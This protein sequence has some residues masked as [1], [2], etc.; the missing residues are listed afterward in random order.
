[1]ENKITAVIIDDETKSRFVLHTLITQNFP[2]IQLIGEASNVDEAYKLLVEV[3]PQLIFLDIQMPKSDGFTLLKHFEK[4][5]FEVVFV[6]SF[7]QYAIW[8]IKFSAL[9]YLLK[10]VEISDLGQAIEK[11]KES[12]S[13][14]R[15]NQSQIV[16]LLRTIED[17]ENQRISIHSA[18]SVIMIEEKS[19]ISIMSDGNYCTIRTDNNDRFISTRRLI[20]FEE[21]FDENSS[22]VR[23]T[24]RHII[25]TTK[26][27]KYSKGEPCIIE[28]TNDEVFE[29]S[30]RRKTEVLN[31]LKK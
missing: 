12:I 20:D 14:K 9:D 22:F 24:R 25:N 7:D 21:Y 27:I 2:E 18:D 19:I 31:K 10:P 28:M 11:A 6:T 15:N 13:L 29:V 26:I 3:K 4:V 23:I 17:S 5:P 30:R 16:N 1:M 8:A